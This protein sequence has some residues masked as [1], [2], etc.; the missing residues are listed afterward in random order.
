MKNNNFRI[1]VMAMLIALL[2]A[3]CASLQSMTGID[4]IKM[5]WDK[6]VKP[7]IQKLLANI[8]VKE[9][10]DIDNFNDGVYLY[11]VKEKKDEGK[12]LMNKG[13]KNASPEKRKALSTGLAILKQ[14]MV[15]PLA[16]HKEKI[17]EVADIVAAPPSES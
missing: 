2:S 3:S 1:I 12:K 5:A 17:G 14:V 9:Q 15:G 6:G 10:E 7:E 4:P 8:D 16:E 13:L 11:V